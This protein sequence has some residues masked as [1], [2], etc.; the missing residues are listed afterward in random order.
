M[1][2]TGTKTDRLSIRALE[3]SDITAWES[4]FDNNPALPYLG[5]DL[6]KNKQEQSQEWIQW[7]LKRYDENRYGH[8]ALIHQQTNELIGQCG[9][10]SQEID[11]KKEI[12]IGYHI[13]P[14]YWGHGYATE[15]AKK[16]RDYAFE[17][18]ISD[19][20]ISVID[21]RNK[22]SQNVAKKIGMTNEKQIKYFDLD[23]FI[24]RIN[25]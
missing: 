3:F 13:L 22:A 24:Y 11:G 7:Q 6:S 23:V 14:K 20:L 18:K 1:Y 15:A 8:H 16:F 19:S 2:L 5:L 9:L 10:L 21:I 4:F 25:Y 12:E 17:N